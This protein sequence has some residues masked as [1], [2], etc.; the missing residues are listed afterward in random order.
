MS[1]TENQLE[2]ERLLSSIPLF[3]IIDDTYVQTHFWNCFEE[4]NKDDKYYAD[5]RNKILTEYFVPNKDV[6]FQA[7]E[8][9]QRIHENPEEGY[10]LYIQVVCSGCGNEL[11][12]GGCCSQCY[13]SPKQPMEFIYAGGT[14]QYKYPDEAIGYVDDGKYGTPYDFINVTEW[15]A[16]VSDII[17]KHM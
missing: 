3:D 5:S 12:E 13:V 4:K 14:S 9:A 8:C 10:D 16:Y 17:S 1:R 7:K 2:L 15:L 11:V 6:L